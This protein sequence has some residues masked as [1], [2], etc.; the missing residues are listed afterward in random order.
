MC[1][2]DSQDVMESNLGYDA[3]LAAPNTCLSALRL[4]IGLPPSARQLD[5]LE[6]V[7]RYLEACQ[8]ECQLAGL[9]L[10][11]FAE[12]YGVESCSNINSQCNVDATNGDC[13]TKPYLLNECRL[14]W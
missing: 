1:S 8:S 11:A 6:S 4:A 9:P 5:R 3:F 2:K 12:P 7:G 14:S 10:L 13:A